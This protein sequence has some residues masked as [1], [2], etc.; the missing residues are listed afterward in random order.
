[1]SVNEKSIMERGM[2]SGT[3]FS[4]QGVWV[5]PDPPKPETMGKDREK[6]ERGPLGSTEKGPFRNKLSCSQKFLSKKSIKRFIE[7]DWVCPEVQD[8]YFAPS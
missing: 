6:G 8:K 4:L 5:S 7:R 1:M 3:S 2:I